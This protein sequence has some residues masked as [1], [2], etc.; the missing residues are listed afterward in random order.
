[1]DA[2]TYLAVFDRGTREPHAFRVRP[3]SGDMDAAAWRVA[4][5]WAHFSELFRRTDLGYVRIEP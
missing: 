4:S 5:K 1:M 3:N 2:G